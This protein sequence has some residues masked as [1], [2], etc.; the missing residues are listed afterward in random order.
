[1]SSHSMYRILPPSE[2]PDG[3]RLRRFRLA[4][5]GGTQ[6][7]G[8][9]YLSAIARLQGFSSCSPATFPHQWEVW[10]REASRAAA[11]A[12]PSA[13][14][15]FVIRAEAEGRTEWGVA[16]VWA[17][18]PFL[19]P[20]FGGERHPPAPRRLPP[21]MP[22]KANCCCPARVQHSV[23]CPGDGRAAYGP[24]MPRS[25]SRRQPRQRVAQHVVC[26]EGGAHVLGWPRRGRERGPAG[27]L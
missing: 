21:A 14:R 3:E 20:A 8:S 22:G 18:N 16:S 19:P 13:S 6:L 7:R 17:G 26:R 15:I 24:A 12:P 4:V 11:S 23:L 27:V 9:W 5:V 1:M 2:P 25:S 10:W